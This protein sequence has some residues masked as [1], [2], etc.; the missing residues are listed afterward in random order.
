MTRLL[1]KFD[2]RSKKNTTFTIV[3]DCILKKFTG[4]KATFIEKILHF[5][6]YSNLVDKN[7]N[8]RWVGY[9]QERWAELLNVDR[10]TIGR[11]KKDLAELGI[12]VAKNLNPRKSD[13]MLW[14]RIDEQALYNYINSTTTK[15]SRVVTKVDQKNYII[16]SLNKPNIPDDKQI[17]IVKEKSYPQCPHGWG[18]MSQTYKENNIRNIYNTPPKSP[19]QSTDVKKTQEGK[20]V[21]LNTK[22]IDFKDPKRINQLQRKLD[23]QY[24]AN[25][26]KHMLNLWQQIVVPKLQKSLNWNILPKKLFAFFKNQMQA[27]MDNW[28]VYLEKIASSDFLTG[29]ISIQ[30]KEQL[31]NPDWAVNLSWIVRPSNF[32]KIEQGKYGVGGIAQQEHERQIQQ[33]IEQ[34]FNNEKEPLFKEIRKQLI[35][36]YGAE[37]YLCWF[38]D[39]KFVL[40]Q[41]KG[42]QGICK[43]QFNVDW[44]HDNYLYLIEH[45]FASNDYKFNTFIYL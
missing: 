38:K 37:K 27:S 45:L 8:Q 3:E 36:R 21:N 43:N 15:V 10:K 14:Y 33:E 42:V 32:E 7:T 6:K 2:E 29:N 35:V 28:R 25:V 1:Q 18:K 24:Q 40:N 12:L 16:H 31:N 22:K 4:K 11:Y 19:S 5:Q 30:E 17:T 44:L 41:K 34:T 9:T 26:T 13:H 23:Q 20:V 39:V